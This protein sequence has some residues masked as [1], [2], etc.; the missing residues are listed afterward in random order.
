MAHKRKIKDIKKQKFIKSV[1]LATAKRGQ[2][3]IEKI[4]I[5]KI[6]I[7]GRGGFPEIKR[8]GVFEHV[9]K[10]TKCGLEFKVYS[11]QEN[12]HTIHNTY[13]PE[14]GQQGNYLHNIHILSTMKEFDLF[15][16]GEIFRQCRMF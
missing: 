13:C 12:R 6:E 11:W 7:P 14:C 8:E 10:C 16:K 3:T 9:F 2:I 5:K 1:D 4:P 15:D